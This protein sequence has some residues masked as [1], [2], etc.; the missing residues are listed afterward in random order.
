MKIIDLFLVSIY[1][2]FCKMRDRGR[3]VIP[4]FQT[5]TSI[6]LFFAITIAFLVK[7]CLGKNFNNQTAPE[8]AFIL[9][10][11]IVGAICFFSTKRYFFKNER[12]LKLSEV[13]MEKYSE[14]E[15]RHIKIRSILF[16]MIIPFILGFL[17][18]FN[19][20]Q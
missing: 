19:A 18:W 14:R 7:V 9:G 13:Y 15:R 8:G 10:F 12:Y 1:L 20:T 5:L 16:I 4:W 6:S 3:K 11:L 2:H 17:I